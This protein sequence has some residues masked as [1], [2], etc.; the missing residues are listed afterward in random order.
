MF[1]RGSAINFSGRGSAHIWTGFQLDALDC[2]VHWWRQATRG[3]SLHERV[4]NATGMGSG[5]LESSAIVVA[6]HGTDGSRITAKHDSVQSIR[7]FCYNGDGPL[8]RGPLIDIEAGINLPLR[9]GVGSGRKISDT[10]NTGMDAGEGSRQRVAAGSLQGAYYGSEGLRLKKREFHSNLNCCPL[11]R[12]KPDSR[13]ERSS[14]LTN[15]I[16]VWRDPAASKWAGDEREAHNGNRCFQRPVSRSRYPR[17]SPNVV[18][19]S[20]LMDDRDTQIL[21]G[22]ARHS[23]SAPATKSRERSS[24]FGRLKEDGEDTRTS[25]TQPKQKDH[26]KTNPRDAYDNEESK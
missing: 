12:F 3:F 5:K 21:S 9:E 26:S 7:G 19:G 4:A 13:V 23:S 15:S 17:T 1:Q 14:T 24:A 2:Q 20:S 16:R 8:E 11:H 22:R 10:F 25:G 18:H 6:P